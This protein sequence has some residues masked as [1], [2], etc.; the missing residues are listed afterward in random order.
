MTDMLKSLALLLPMATMAEAAEVS[1]SVQGFASEAGVADIVIFDSAES[2]LQDG[3]DLTDVCDTDIVAIL[4]KRSSFNCDLPPGSYAILVY[5]DENQ[6]GRL[7]VTPKRV[8][9][10]P[11]GF[12]N[13]API[14]YDGPP[15]YDEAKFS[16]G[17]DKLELVI[18]L[19][20]Y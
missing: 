3:Q 16:V 7:D 19:Q 12:S 6:N 1:V 14:A 17:T 13:D 18:N 10:E 15:V 2:F 9:L 8:P 20:F 4:D 5:H 11:V